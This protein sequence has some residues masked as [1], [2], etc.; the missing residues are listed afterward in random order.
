MSIKIE[1]GVRIPSD[2]NGTVK[3]TRGRNRSEI[4]VALEGMAPGQSFKVKRDELTQLAPA[5]SATTKANR[6]RS[7]YYTSSGANHVRVWRTA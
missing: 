3:K 7:Y 6:G 1:N 2:Y 4:R 5:I